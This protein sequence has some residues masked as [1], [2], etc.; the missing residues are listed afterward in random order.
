MESVRA[1][2]QANPGANMLSLMQMSANI[3]K[4]QNPTVKGGPSDWQLYRENTRLKEKASKAD[5]QLQTRRGTTVTTLLGDE[6][7]GLL[8]GTD[9]EIAARFE[10]STKPVLGERTWDR[11]ET[12]GF[13]DRQIGTVTTGESGPLKLRAFVGRRVRD[14]AMWMLNNGY[15][16]HAVRIVMARMKEAGMASGK[17]DFVAAWGAVPSEIAE[18]I[19]Q[20]GGQNQGG[21]TTNQRAQSHQVRLPNS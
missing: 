2:M 18:N 12:W 15:D 6:F 8:K 5:T 7:G 9:A 10:P 17:F 4:L 21:G 11:P 20:P 3:N 1:A 16:E 14:M 13:G 19:G